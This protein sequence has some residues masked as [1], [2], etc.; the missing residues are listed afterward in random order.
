MKELHEKISPW[1]W[2]GVL[3]FRI[4]FEFFFVKLLFSSGFIQCHS[5]LIRDTRG[6]QIRES[7]SRV[8]D[9]I[10][11]GI[12]KIKFDQGIINVLELHEQ[13]LEGWTAAPLTRESRVVEFEFLVV[14]EIMIRA[15]AAKTANDRV[16]IQ[17]KKIQPETLGTEGVTTATPLYREEELFKTNGTG[18][19][20]NLIV[21]PAVRYFFG[22]LGGWECFVD[23]SE[24]CLDFWVEEVV[25]HLK[26][27]CGLKLT[28]DAVMDV[29]LCR[30]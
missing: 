22:I 11:L 24:G 19:F 15:T 6:S 28:V 16:M 14:L 1:I 20:I 4:F 21:A 27:G 5:Q 29:S 12:V 18:I 23:S 8:I 30:H 9:N 13:K 17:I 26:T 7:Q 10:E 25:R 3:V 2:V